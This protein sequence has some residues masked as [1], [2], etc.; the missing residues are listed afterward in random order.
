MKKEGD[1][2][3]RLTQI[4]QD[5][6][7]EEREMLLIRA[8]ANKQIAESRLLAEDDTKSNE[9]RLEALKKAVAEEQRVAQIELAIQQLKVDA[10][11]AM[12]DLGK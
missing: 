5:V 12:I 8:K 11:Q 9:E 7:D 3:M 4:M 1:E 2:A 6:R 10:M